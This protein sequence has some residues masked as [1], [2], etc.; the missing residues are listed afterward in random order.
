MR[1]VLEALEVQP[2]FGYRVPARRG[3]PAKDVLIAV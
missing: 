3:H 2:L 1:R